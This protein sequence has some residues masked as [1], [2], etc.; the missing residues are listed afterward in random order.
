MS[1][2]ACAIRTTRTGTT[3]L[4]KAA[5]NAAITGHREIIRPLRKTRLTGPDIKRWQINEG[6]IPGIKIRRYEPFLDSLNQ[7]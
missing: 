6:Q 2:L 5:S 3:G 4:G 7:H 1:G